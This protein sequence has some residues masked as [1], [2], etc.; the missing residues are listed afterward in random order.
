[1]GLPY[2]KVDRIA[3]LVPDMTKSLAEAAKEVDALAPEVESDPEVRQIVEVGEPA[4]RADPPRLGAR[5]RRRHHAAPAR[6]A[7]AALQG[8]KGDEE[9][10]MTQ[11]DMNVVEKLG[12]LKMDFLGLRT[13]T[14]LDDAVKILR[15]Q[16]IELDLDEMPLD[17]PE[18]FR[19]FCDGRTS[20]IFQ[21]ESRGMTDLLRRAQPSRFEDLAA[22]NAL[23]RPGALSV[24]MV[25]EYIQRKHGK[26][27]VSYLAA[28]R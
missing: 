27:K 15:Q 26:R 12:L 25:D 23:Y 14:V 21:F 19:L 2:A 13:L 22:F 1:M 9:Q 8:T 24:G 11:W 18:V 7:R 17:D 5:R 4:R 28:A 16:G 20:G 6:R 10:V 3:K